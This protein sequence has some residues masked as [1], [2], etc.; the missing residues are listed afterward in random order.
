MRLDSLVFTPRALHAP[1]HVPDFCPLPF[2]AREHNMSCLPASIH[3]ARSIATAIA[4]APH[5]YEKWSD[6]ASCGRSDQMWP[7]VALAPPLQ[8]L[9]IPCRFAAIACRP[10][11]DPLHIPAASLRF[12]SRPLQVSCMSLGYSLGVSLAAGLQFM[13]LACPAVSVSVVRLSCLAI[14]GSVVRLQ[15]QGNGQLWPGVARC[16][17]TWPGVARCGQ[18]WPVVARCDQM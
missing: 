7:V 10:L 18:V 4:Q 3:F 1:Y 13:L 6:V 15:R 8:T 14:S 9:Q 5:V 16:G 2:G 12:L 11:A 17:Q